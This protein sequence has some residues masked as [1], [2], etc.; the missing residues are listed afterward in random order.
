MPK[1]CTSNEPICEDTKPTKT[2]IGTRTHGPF[3]FFNIYLAAW[4]LSCGLKHLHCLIR[5]LLLQYTDSLVVVLRFQSSQAASGVAVHGH[6]RSAACRISAPTPRIEPKFSALQC[7]SLTTGP[8]GKFSIH[9]LLIRITHLVSEL[10]FFES[11]HRRNSGRG[12]VI[13]RK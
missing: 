5:D 6:R 13:G 8:P 7:G 4:G 10:G 2:Q 9:C 12:K 1:L 11:Q 3:Y